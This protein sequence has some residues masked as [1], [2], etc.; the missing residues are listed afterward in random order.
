MAAE[1]WNFEDFGETED[2]FIDE[3]DDDSP[4]DAQ[5]GLVLN[6]R[7][8]LAGEDIFN[9]LTSCKTLGILGDGISNLDAI[10]R[11]LMHSK[12]KGAVKVLIVNSAETEERGEHWFL[13]LLIND[14]LFMFDSFGREIETL[15][16]MAGTPLPRALSRV[17]TFPHTKW[18]N[19]ASVACGYYCV[20]M[21]ITLNDTKDYTEAVTR[22]RLYFDSTEHSVMR[23]LTDVD[24][25]SQTSLENDTRCMEIVAGVAK[26]YAQNEDWY[27][28]LLE[29]L[30]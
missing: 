6:P 23:V 13:L 14:R 3:D 29:A 22:M 5:V 7:L 16:K 27:Q 1:D 30:N 8:S 28:E 2:F 25:L 18:Q 4:S 19:P 10:T 24:P 12:R 20:L 17:T 21:M 26:S 11:N 15:F 9:V